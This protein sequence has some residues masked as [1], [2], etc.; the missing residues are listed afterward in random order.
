MSFIH[1]YYYMDW[2]FFC[3]VILWLPADDYDCSSQRT[4]AWAFCTWCQQSGTHILREYKAHLRNEFALRMFATERIRRMR[5]HEISENS[6]NEMWFERRTRPHLFSHFNI[7]TC[8]W[9]SPALSTCTIRLPYRLDCCIYFLRRTS[10]A[11]IRTSNSKCNFRC[12]RWWRRLT[13]WPLPMDHVQNAIWQTL[14]GRGVLY[15]QQSQC[16]VCVRRVA[17][18]NLVYHD[19]IW[20]SARTKSTTDFSC[21]RKY[22][23]LHCPLRTWLHFSWLLVAS[24]DRELH[25]TAPHRT[26][27]PELLILFVAIEWWAGDVQCFIPLFY[28]L[29]HFAVGWQINKHNARFQP[30]SARYRAHMCSQK[31]IS[32]FQKNNLTEWDFSPFLHCFSEVECMGRSLVHSTLPSPLVALFTFA[33]AVYILFSQS[34]RSFAEK[35]NK[36]YNLFI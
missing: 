11:Y 8:N 23:Y 22:G 32:K 30:D 35:K 16:G 5:L 19:S 12:V 33:A 27:T 2:E 28:S 25:F 31:N 20:T 24:D 6:P 9:T 7:I 14:L 1:S 18:S 17:Q 36:K 21:I 4:W 3:D 29:L 13:K 10:S 34:C 26:H 15:A